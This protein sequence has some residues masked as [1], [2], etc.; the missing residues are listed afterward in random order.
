MVL[1]ISFH[2]DVSITSF[3]GLK[4]PDQRAP[5]RRRRFFRF[6]QVNSIIYNS[7]YCYGLQELLI[8]PLKL[9]IKPRVVYVI[10]SCFYCIQRTSTLVRTSKFNCISYRSGPDPFIFSVFVVVRTPAFITVHWVWAARR[11]FGRGEVLRHGV[12]YTLSVHS[13][14][15]RTQ[16]W[17]SRPLYKEV[18]E[19][20]QT[21][22]LTYLLV[23]FYFLSIVYLLYYLFEP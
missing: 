11:S 2:H 7:H 12:F 23:Y 19:P 18:P 21:R 9:S 4:S 22:H 17:S 14:V 15:R 5:L 3:W 10:L 20:L 1:C 13:T 6:Q 16:L 8:L